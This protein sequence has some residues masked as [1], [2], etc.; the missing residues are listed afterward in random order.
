MGK[1]K[2]TKLDLQDVLSLI[3][4]DGNDESEQMDDQSAAKL[5]F[6]KA[7]LAY[8]IFLKGDQK[9]INDAASSITKACKCDRES[10]YNHETAAMILV[11]KYRRNTEKLNQS[12]DAE[13]NLKILKRAIMLGKIAIKLGS[14]QASTFT[15]VGKAYDQIGK[16]ERA[17]KYHRRAAKLDATSPSNSISGWARPL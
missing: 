10:T 14:I 6:T 9:M 4:Q 3:T 12:P 17:A 15:D 5:H 8:N 16:H 11:L 2:E 7:I 13:S 1:K